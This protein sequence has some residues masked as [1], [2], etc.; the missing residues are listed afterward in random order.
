MKKTQVSTGGE[1]DELQGDKKTANDT[2]KHGD[3]EHSTCNMCVGTV[4]I[5]TERNS[6]T[7]SD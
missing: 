2:S 3:Q 1:G 4:S 7:S 6:Q 5:S